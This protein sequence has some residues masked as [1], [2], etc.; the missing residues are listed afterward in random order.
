MSLERLVAYFRGPGR[1]RPA[2]AAL[3]RI[4]LRVDVEPDCIIRSC[5]VSSK[6]CDDGPT[7]RAQSFG[8]AFGVH[9]RAHAG[10]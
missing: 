4:V 3:L 6:G 7:A 2:V 8:P 5:A 9:A 1:F 10:T